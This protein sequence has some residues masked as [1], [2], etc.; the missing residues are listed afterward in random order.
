MQAL[1]N[2][3]IKVALAIALPFG[4]MISATAVA[5]SFEEAKVLA[6]H[7][8]VRGQSLLGVYY[9]NGMGVRQDYGKAFYWYQKSANQGDEF[10]QVSMGFA[11]SSGQGVR[12]DFTKA[13][14]WYQKAAKKNN[15]F[16]QVAI[17]A[18]YEGGMGVRL[19]K[20]T[21]KEWYGKA[22]DNGD[23]IGCNYYRELNEQG[24]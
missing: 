12:Q 24:Y 8:D 21:A 9:A 1:K 22:C 13:L 23:Q 17:G 18:M 20:T 4:S 16:A 5:P 10:A 19:N 11:Y 14:E 15:P 2:K 3:A 6:E 7:G